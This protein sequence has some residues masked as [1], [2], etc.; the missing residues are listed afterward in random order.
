MGVTLMLLSM[1]KIVYMNSQTT[2]YNSFIDRGF[3]VFDN[4]LIEKEGLFVKRDV[5]MNPRL[6]YN[7]YSYERLKS[8]LTTIF[9]A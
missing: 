3:K 4:I 8:S 7:E 6:V 5:S 1:S 9:N 2:S